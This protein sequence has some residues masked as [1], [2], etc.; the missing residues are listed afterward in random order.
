M[1]ISSGQFRTPDA[2]AWLVATIAVTTASCS[3][4]TCVANRVRRRGRGA[5]A[6]TAGLAVA[7]VASGTA[8]ELSSV[9]SAS[10]GGDRGGA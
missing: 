2:Q 1:Q 4:S 6:V 5:G 9:T 7:R 3:N 10:V 8:R